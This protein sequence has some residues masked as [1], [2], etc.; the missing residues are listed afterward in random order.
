MGDGNEVMMVVEYRR[1]GKGKKTRIRG[2]RKEI[3]DEDAKK[4]ILR[5]LSVEMS[6]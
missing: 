4:I 2:I 5:W 6:E 3:R 1:K